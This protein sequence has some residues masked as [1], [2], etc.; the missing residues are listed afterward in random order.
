MGARRVWDSVGSAGRE[1]ALQ[2]ARGLASK[3]KRRL[4]FNKNTNTKP[5][6]GVSLITTKPRSFN[7]GGRQQLILTMRDR[8][9]WTKVV[10][11]YSSMSRGGI[12]SGAGANILQNQDNG[13]LPIRTYDLTYKPW[14]AQAESYLDSF[15]WGLH[16]GNGWV[17]HF[18]NQ[19]EA[20]T[21]FTT[22]PAII[23]K[24]NGLSEGG[25]LDRITTWLEQ[26]QQIKLMLYG[27]AKQS[28][29][30]RVIFWRTDEEELN[31]HILAIDANWDTTKQVFLPMVQQFTTNPASVSFNR[32]PSIGLKNKRIKILK[33]FDYRIKEQL[34]TEDMTNRLTLHY[35]VYINKLK[36]HRYLQF[37]PPVTDIT[38]VDQPTITA[39]TTANA[40]R[41]CNPNQRIY[42]SIIGECIEVEGS[43]Q[44]EAPSFDLGIKQTMFA[45]N[46]Q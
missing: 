46:I 32:Y 22:N 41:Y 40:T 18:S 42:M 7:I 2:V 11:V 6:E 12:Q 8:P 20:V 29:R 28:T 26:K 34:S 45:S 44:Y 14:L 16:Q 35:N 19:N 37:T 36:N 15:G 13:L 17:N 30:Y 23:Y 25:H 43:A 24:D 1:K 33:Q 4:N 10:T 9:L 31:P 21:Q 27:R 5:V 3:A 38:N 39:T